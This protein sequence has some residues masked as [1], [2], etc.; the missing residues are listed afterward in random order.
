MS[1]NQRITVRALGAVLIAVFAMIMAG[2]GGG[3][4]PPMGMGGQAPVDTAVMEST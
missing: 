1:A 4:P 3:A 2:C